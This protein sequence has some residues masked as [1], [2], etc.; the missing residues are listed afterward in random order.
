MAAALSGMGFVVLQV[1]GVGLNDFAV[2]DKQETHFIGGHP[3]NKRLRFVE[4]LTQPGE[5][6]L[7]VY[8]LSGLQRPPFGG[9]IVGVAPDLSHQPLWREARRFLD[10]GPNDRPKRQNSLMHCHQVN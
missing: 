5:N 3:G 10:S 6:V 8:R 2:V 1:C 9:R 7:G 4:R